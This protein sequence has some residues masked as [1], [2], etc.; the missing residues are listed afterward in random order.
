M[1]S[2]VEI[3]RS[4]QNAKEI[5]MTFG[6]LENLFFPEVT[7]A[8]RLSNPLNGF[9]CSQGNASLNCGASHWF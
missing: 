5:S 3:I 8:Y 6:N 7:D 1:H 4:I 9:S 2:L